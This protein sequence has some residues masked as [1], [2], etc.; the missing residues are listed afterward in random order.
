MFLIS[1]IFRC[2][3]RSILFCTPFTFISLQNFLPFSRI[4]L[5]SFPPSVFF[6]SNINYI[7]A[8]SSYLLHFSFYSQLQPCLFIGLFF[9]FIFMHCSLFIVFSCLRL[10]HFCVCCFYFLL[11]Q[12]LL[13]MISMRILLWSCFPNRLRILLPELQ[14]MHIIQNLETVYSLRVHEFERNMAVTTQ[15]HITIYHP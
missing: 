10:S 6:I 7:R 15:K 2:S 5:Y 8:V 9:F 12:P 11:P 3:F 14:I 1:S 4:F 13:T